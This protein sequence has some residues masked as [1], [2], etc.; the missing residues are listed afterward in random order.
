D[1]DGAGRLEARRELDVLFALERAGEARR[2][3]DRADGAAGLGL[4]GEEEPGA[5]V[6]VVRY[7]DRVP[8]ALAIDVTADGDG[9]RRVVLRLADPE[10]EPVEQLR[11]DPGDLIGCDLE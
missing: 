6:D 5:R 10:A 11:G 4:L 8:A 2:D 3:A 9:A 1:L 7:R